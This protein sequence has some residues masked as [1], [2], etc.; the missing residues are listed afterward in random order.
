MRAQAFKVWRRFV[1]SK[2]VS[3]YKTELTKQLFVLNPIFQKAMLT[4]KEH[5]C[6]IADGP[7]R[8]KLHSLKSGIVFRLEDFV[9]AQEK[10]AEE[11][12]QSLKELHDAT[13]KGVKEVREPRC[14][15]VRLSP[16]GA[17]ACQGAR[18]GHLACRQT[19]GRPL[20]KHPTMVGATPRRRALTHC[21]S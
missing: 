16:Q 13:L 19:D 7:D 20:R 18:T 1:K 4:I 8:L 6:L 9:L 12:V 14:R 5:C 3:V 21:R 2:K 10:Q 11:V 15:R 17:V